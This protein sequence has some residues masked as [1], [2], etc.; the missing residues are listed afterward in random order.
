MSSGTMS[1]WVLNVIVLLSHA[2]KYWFHFLGASQ[3]KEIK[4]KCRR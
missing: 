2:I 4:E 1:W 3:L